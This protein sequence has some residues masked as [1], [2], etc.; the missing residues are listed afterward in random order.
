MQNLQNLRGKN[1]LF[2]CVQTFNLEKDIIQQLEKHGAH[3]TYFDERPSNSNLIKGLIRLK[4]NLLEKRIKQY[5]EHILQQIAGKKFDYL[6]VNRGEVVTEDFLKAFVTQQPNCQRIFYTWDSFGNHSHALSILQY[7]DKR[8]TFDKNDANKYGIGFRPLYF[9]DAYREVK[10][11]MQPQNIDL[12]FLGTAH[13][14][15]YVISNKIADW[16]KD[17]GLNSYNYYYMQGRL[18]FFYKKFF[19][20]SFGHFD[21]KKLS[22]KSLTTKQII[23]LYKKSKV[24]LDISHPGQSGLTMRT[25][26]SIGAGRKI[27]TTNTNIKKYPFYHVDNF[28][29]L[30]RKNLKL[31]KDFF[32]KPYQPLDNKLYEK[33]SIDGWLEDIFFGEEENFWRVNTH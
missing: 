11:T 26:E 7:F 25:F 8:F 18:V 1:V 13:S 3:V 29:I 32:M 23:E 2:L 10:Q 24:I 6:F 28:Y 27:I 17:N 14:D 4:R 12:L 19:D 15:R 22:F 21:Y 20:K 31:T 16:C 33:C 5:Y 30:D 9:I